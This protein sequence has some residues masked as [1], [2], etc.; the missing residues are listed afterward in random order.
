MLLK[1]SQ[2]KIETKNRRNALSLSSRNFL[3][4]AGWTKVAM[5]WLALFLHVQEVLDP[6]LDTDNKYTPQ[7]ITGIEYWIRLKVFR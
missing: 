7:V 3:R 5:E 2:W 6:N 1:V 4:S